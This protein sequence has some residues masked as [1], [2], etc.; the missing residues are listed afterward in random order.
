MLGWTSIVNKRN[1]RLACQL[2]FDN[3]SVSFGALLFFG[4]GWA[5]RGGQL[6]A[7]AL[8]F[9]KRLGTGMSPTDISIRGRRAC[10]SPA[11]EG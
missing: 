2:D 6:L 10:P 1:I 4:R 11:D 8:H 3:G 5:G 9:P 7:T